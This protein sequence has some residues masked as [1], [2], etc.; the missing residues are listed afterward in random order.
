MMRTIPF[1]NITKDALSPIEEFLY[2]KYRSNVD[3][4]KSRNDFT[5]EMREL[6][7]RYPEIAEKFCDFC[8]SVISNIN[9]TEDRYMSE[10]LDISVYSN[11]RYFPKKEH[12]HEFFEIILVLNGQCQNEVE[13]TMLTLSVGDICFLAPNVPHRIIVNSHEGLVYNILIR[14]STFQ[15]TFAHIYGSDD[16]ISD[17]FTRNLYRYKQGTSPYIICK[18]DKEEVY[19]DLLYKMI[20]EE[21]NPGKF[22]NRYMNNLFQTFILEILRQHEYHFTIGEATDNIE[23]E[24]ITAILKYIQGN[25]N[26]LNLSETAR[27][28]HYSEAHLSRLIKKFTGQNFS[29]IIQ[30]I[31]IQKALKLLLETNKS[32]A[33][34]VEEIG[35]SDNSHFYKIFKQH[36]GMTPIQYKA[37]KNIK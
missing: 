1:H 11:L 7:L 20:E 13:G 23:F 18:T 2:E 14:T 17:F 36:Y 28:F 27:F 16:I 8:H 35:Y 3:E 30:T 31:K 34:I 25:Y 26:H 12:K 37:M 15:E 5:P 24:S 10:G 22:S 6:S 29:G 4:M 32:I 19:Q 9:C 33:E 21:Q